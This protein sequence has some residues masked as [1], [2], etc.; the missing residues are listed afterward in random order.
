MTKVTS[1][2]TKILKRA[3]GPIVHGE[4]FVFTCYKSRD[5][6]FKCIPSSR[7]TTSLRDLSALRK[8]EVF[9]SVNSPT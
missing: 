3:L 2:S 4:N 8:G 7:V 1:H 6:F 9:R 5:A